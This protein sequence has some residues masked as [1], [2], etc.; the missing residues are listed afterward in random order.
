[1]Q[2][3]PFA[4]ELK[5]TRR[6]QADERLERRDRYLRLVLSVDRLEVRWVVPGNT[7]LFAV[8]HGDHDAVEGTDP[9]HHPTIT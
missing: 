5:R 4:H 1:M 2:R 9:R 3:C 6:Q 7:G 8:I